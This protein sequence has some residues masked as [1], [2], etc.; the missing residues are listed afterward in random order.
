MTPLPAY[1][2]LTPPSTEVTVSLIESMDTIVTLTIPPLLQPVRLDASIAGALPDLSRVAVRR[3]IDEGHVAVDGILRKASHALLG[4][5]NIRMEIPPPASAEILPQAIPLDILF[6]DSDL[7]VVNKPAGMTVHPGAGTPD[8]TLVNALLAH[9]SDLSGVGGVERPGIVHRIDKD[10]SGVLVVAKNDRTHHGLAALFER[11]DI[12][13]IYYALAHG[14]PKCDT[15]TIK[16]IIGR[17]PTDRVKMSGSAKSGKQAVTHWRVTARYPE[18]ALLRIR[19]ET[20]RTHQIRVHLSEAGHP[21][22]GDSLY[23]NAGRLNNMKDPVL[24]KMIKE[25]GRQA[26]HAGVLGFVHP[27]TGQYCEFTAPLPDDMQRICD[28]LDSKAA[29]DE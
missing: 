8:G 26:L 15:G 18:A 23:G 25:L 6:E 3:L 19:L 1:L 7:V 14:S 16:G 11:H 22:L 4:G 28:Y 10:T 12:K 17:H 20:G 21:L 24:R 5:E 9:C 2:P 29:M 13:R 27:G